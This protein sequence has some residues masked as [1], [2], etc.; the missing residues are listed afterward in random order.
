MPFYEKV[1]KIQDSAAGEI[2]KIADDTKI[3]PLPRSQGGD[4]MV[5]LQPSRAVCYKYLQP[6]ITEISKARMI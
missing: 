2:C 6:R 1:R 4:T 3:I 5:D